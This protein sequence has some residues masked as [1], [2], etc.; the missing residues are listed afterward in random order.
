MI[1]SREIYCDYPLPHI[2]RSCFDVAVLVDAGIADHTVE[3]ATVKYC[4]GD[5]LPNASMI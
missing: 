3:A 2:G 1:A 4:F 5:E